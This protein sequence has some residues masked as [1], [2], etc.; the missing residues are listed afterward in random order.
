MALIVED[1][2]V[3][4]GAESYVTVAE[5]DA[6]HT[7]RGNAA[8]DDVEDKE[9]ALR[10]ATDY[11][12]RMYRQRWK[13]IRKN[14]AQTLDW[15]R[16]MV[17]TEPFMRGGVGE[18]PYLVSNIIV[19]AEVKTACIEFALR[20]A[21]AA[22]APDLERATSQETVG[23]ISVTYDPASSEGTRYR[24]LDA[25]LAPYLES[26]SMNAFVMRR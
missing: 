1:G 2:T 22:L 7:A 23:P 21:A 16:E 8:W 15:P 20:A 19:P 4:A 6:Y 18:Y 24:E 12:V 11:M 13:G 14:I 5:A 10:R 17:Y 25:L 3:V 26:S 9:A